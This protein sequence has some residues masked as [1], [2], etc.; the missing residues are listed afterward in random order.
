MTSTKLK[1]SGMPTKYSDLVAAYPPRPLHDKVDEQNVEEIIFEMAGHRLTHD[2]ED[3]LE[4]LSELLFKYQA[5]RASKSGLRRP[6]AERLKYLIDEAGITSVRLAKL[7]GC[8]QPLVSLI[9]AGKR[10]LTLPHIRALATH[11]RLNP[12]YFV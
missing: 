12:G 4:V 8:S 5:A 3:Y 11:F 2:Q 7:L 10:S 9:L 1:F 6:P